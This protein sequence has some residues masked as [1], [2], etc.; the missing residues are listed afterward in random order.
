MDGKV[1]LGFSRATL[2]EPN[3][4]N[5]P[6][7]HNVNNSAEREHGTRR[8]FNSFISSTSVEPK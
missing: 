3:V 8:L 7:E 6:I 5:D 2:G 4:A 1:V